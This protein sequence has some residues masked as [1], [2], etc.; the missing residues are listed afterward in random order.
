MHAIYYHFTIC[1]SCVFS[2]S[3]IVKWPAVQYEN[4]IKALHLYAS[5]HMSIKYGAWYVQSVIEHQ[6]QSLFG[7]N[8][9]C[10]LCKLNV[11]YWKTNVQNFLTLIYQIWMARERYHWYIERDTVYIEGASSRC[12]NA[13]PPCTDADDLFRCSATIRESQTSLVM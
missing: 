1:L 3:M 4:N 2:L 9:Q 13:P 12:L 10:Q 11:R 6:G 8:C 7:Y 5:F